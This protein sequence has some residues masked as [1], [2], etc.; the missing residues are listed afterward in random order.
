M[1]VHAP[2]QVR[3]SPCLHCNLQTM[4]PL[5]HYGPP[6]LPTV[7]GSMSLLPLPTSHSLEAREKSVVWEWLFLHVRHWCTNLWGCL[8]VISLLTCRHFLVLWRS[9]N[10]LNLLLTNRGCRRVLPT[11][12]VLLHPW[13]SRLHL[14]LFDHL[15]FTLLWLWHLRRTRHRNVLLSVLWL[16]NHGGVRTGTPLSLPFSASASGAGVTSF[17]SSGLYEGESSIVFLPSSSIASCF[18]ARRSFNA[19]SAAWGLLKL[20]LSLTAITGHV[21]PAASPSSYHCGGRKTNFSPFS[22]WGVPFVAFPGVTTARRGS[23][24]GPST[25]THRI[26]VL[27][28]HPNRCC[29]CLRVSSTASRRCWA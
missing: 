29:S 7:P 12:L 22:G 11:L 27:A 16:W 5:L 18:W 13:T 26:G 19:F 6:Q 28:A 15:F 24:S 10:L 2:D 14:F 1:C 21:V 9:T 17:S 20:V 8:F 4:M 25:M 3:I 23:P